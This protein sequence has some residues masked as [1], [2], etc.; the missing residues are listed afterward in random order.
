MR[1]TAIALAL[2]ALAAVASHANPIMT[3]WFY[4]DFAPPGGVYRVDP[5]MYDLVD[6]YFVVDLSMS[7]AQRFT[8]VS[9]RVELTQGMW[10]NPVFTS[11]IPGSVVEGAWNTG[12]TVTAID[13]VES[14][15]APVAKLSFRYLGVPGDVLIRDH[16]LKPR[17]LIDC[18]EPGQQFLYCVWSHGGVG[19]TPVGGDCTGSAVID[20]TWTAIRALYR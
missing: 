12:V 15:P 20:V 10:T 8:S 18:E 2:V 13:C 3:E 17:W 4:V 11:L 5:A 1:H 19:K 7:P 16:P 6:A 14:F 9:F